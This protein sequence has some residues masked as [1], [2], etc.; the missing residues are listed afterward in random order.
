[1]EIL[2]GMLEAI[3]KGADVESIAV[4]EFGAG[5]RTTGDNAAA[6]ASWISPRRDASQPWPFENGIETGDARIFRIQA[7]SRPWGALVVKEW[8]D[9]QDWAD[10]ELG[11]L[12]TLAVAIGGFLDRRRAREALL[13]ENRSLNRLLTGLSETVFHIDL[14]GRWCFLNPA[15][16]E[17]TGYDITS[18][19]GRRFAEFID[20]EDATGT[21]EKFGLLVSGRSSRAESE[22][23]LLHCNG[24]RMWVRV[25]A[26]PQKNRAGKLVGVSGTLVNLTSGHLSQKAMRESEQ[27]FRSWNETF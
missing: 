15:W 13:E 26:R 27:R 9:A 2:P 22:I 21:L 4:L 7:A 24:K 8:P 12:D 20:P 6:R 17:M 23:R 10:E 25:I 3:G 18:S 16:T 11:A 14:D 1:M 19:L 5:D